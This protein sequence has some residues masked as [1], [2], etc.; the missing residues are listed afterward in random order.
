MLTIAWDIDD[1]LNDLMCQ[2]LN[3]KWLADHP[4]CGVSFE[5]ITE[6]TPERIIGAS[7]EE[8]RQSL[9]G[10]RLSRDY[11]LMQPNQEV[12]EWFERNGNKSRHIALTS[13]P[14]KAAHISADWVL[15]NFGKWIRSFNFVPSPRQGED[16][17]EYDVSKVDYLKWLGKVDVLVEDSQENIQEAALLGIKGILIK[18]PWNRSGLLVKDALEEVDKIIDR[19]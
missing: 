10:F 4:E 15:S 16:I 19:G 2:W 17:P 14:L 1:V 3:K 11:F 12:L 9:D 8:Y 18:R 7:L 13:V 6:N 5:Q